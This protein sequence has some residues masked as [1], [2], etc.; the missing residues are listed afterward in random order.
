MTDRARSIRLT[1]RFDAI[2]ES[3]AHTHGPGLAFTSSMAA[4]LMLIENLLSEGVIRAKVDPEFQLELFQ[5]EVHDLLRSIHKDLCDQLKVPEEE[6]L[7]LCMHFN[8]I[9]IDIFQRKG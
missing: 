1:E 2:E 5:R 9:I 8:Q 7:L 3:I 6:S 4:E